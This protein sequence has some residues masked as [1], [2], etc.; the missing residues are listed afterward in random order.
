M[1]TAK[2]GQDNA[3]QECGQDFERCPGHWGYIKL[4]TPKY[5]PEFFDYVKK[6]LIC[7]CL[8]C[9]ALISEDFPRTGE[10]DKIINAA[11]AALVKKKIRGTHCRECKAPLHATIQ[12]DS[13]LQ[14]SLYIVSQE[15]GAPARELRPKRAR[16]ILSR[17]STDAYAM[18]GFSPSVSHPKYFMCKNL[19][20]PPINIRPSD[21]RGRKDVSHNKLTIFLQRILVDNNTLGERIQGLSEAKRKFQSRLRS[22]GLPPETLELL[23]PCKSTL[24]HLEGNVFQRQ[25]DTPETLAQWSRDLQSLAFKIQAR[26]E[27]EEEEEEEQPEN[28]TVGMELA[29]AQDLATLGQLSPG[30][31]VLLRGWEADLKRRKT[32]HNQVCSGPFSGISLPN[33]G[34]SLLVAIE[35]TLPEL[36]ERLER[37][38]RIRTVESWP[39]AE[40]WSKA[41]ARVLTQEKSLQY[42]IVCYV[43]GKISAPKDLPPRT[44]IINTAP[45]YKKESIQGRLKGTETKDGRFRDNISGK[46]NENAGRAVIDPGQENSIDQVTESED[47]AR[48]LTTN[49]FVYAHNIERMR[50]YVANGTKVYPGAKKI[51][52][53]DGNVKTLDGLS[54]AELSDPNIIN[55]GDEVCR[56]LVTDDIV[57]M[58]RQPT[59]HTGS[60]MAHRA[61]VTKQGNTFRLNP[62]VMPPYNADCDG[63]EM[64]QHVPT[65]IDTMTE[66]ETLS[67]T[68]KM[69]VSPGS[70]SPVIGFIQDTL[71]GSRLFLRDAPMFNE[72]ELLELVAYAFREDWDGELPPQRTAPGSG[73]W[74]ASDIFSMLLYPRLCMRKNTKGDGVF[75]ILGGV[76]TQGQISKDILGTAHRSLIHVINNDFGPEAA[77]LFIDRMQFMINHWL[78]SRGFTFSAADLY[79]DERTAGAIRE[80]VDEGV[81]RYMAEN[82]SQSNN[83]QVSIEA[84]AAARDRVIEELEGEIDERR[85]N[86]VTMKVAGS[87]GSQDNIQQMLGSLGQQFVHGK[88]L[89]PNFSRNISN[90][91]SR[92]SNNNTHLFEPTLPERGGTTSVG[93]RRHLEEERY[94]AALGKSK[95]LAQSMFGKFTSTQC[96]F[97]PSAHK[98][99]FVG[100]SFRVGLSAVE[101]FSHAFAGREGLIDTA[102]KTSDIGYLQRKFIK[103]LEDLSVRYDSTVRNARDEVY[104]FSYGNDNFNPIHLESSRLEV[105]QMSTAQREARLFWSAEVEERSELARREHTKIARLLEKLARVSRQFNSNGEIALP[106]DLDRM[107]MSLDCE[108]H[109]LSESETQRIASS[110]SKSARYAEAVVSI[111]EEFRSAYEREVDPSVARKNSSNTIACMLRLMLNSKACLHKWRLSPEGLRHMLFD[112]A[113]RKFLKALVD[114]GEP[115]GPVAAVCIGEPATQMTLNTFHSAGTGGQGSVVATTGV[116]RLTEVTEAKVDQTSVLLDLWTSTPGHEMALCT[117][118]QGVVL[119]DLVIHSQLLLSSEQV[120]RY[121]GLDDSVLRVFYEMQTAFTP[122]YHEQYHPEVLRIVLDRELLEALAISIESIETALRTRKYVADTRLEVIASRRNQLRS[123]AVATIL[124]SNLPSA[125]DQMQLLVERFS[126]EGETLQPIIVERSRKFDL[127]FE[128]ASA[129]QTLELYATEVA[130]FRAS[131]VEQQVALVRIRAKRSARR[132]NPLLA[133]ELRRAILEDA[134]IG[135][136]SFVK[137]S[138]VHTEKRQVLNPETGETEMLD[139]TRV[140]LSVATESK[141]KDCLG[142][143]FMLHGI[144]HSRVYSNNIHHIYET[145]G[146]GAAKIAIYKEVMKVYKNININPRLVMLMVNAMTRTGQIVSC[147]WFGI[148]KTERTDPIKA[149]MFERCMKVLPRASAYGVRNDERS[150]NMAIMNTQGFPMGT[151]VVEIEDNH[152]MLERYGIEQRAIAAPANAMLARYARQGRSRH[153]DESYLFESF[154]YDP[155][156]AKKRSQPQYHTEPEEKRIKLY[157]PLGGHGHGARH[158]PPPS[159]RVQRPLAMNQKDSAAKRARIAEKFRQEN[160]HL[161]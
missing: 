122:T 94:N 16:K 138:K 145:L 147:N 150:I 9:C 56:M 161:F 19:P 140:V 4:V 124:K 116:P 115:V 133:K 89:E 160:P 41:F 31:L 23:L 78:E 82:A 152:E 67:K 26:L 139:D 54:N 49:E 84:L 156:L 92:S 66:I 103:T 106:V 132:P 47:M 61:K 12:A 37:A 126:I 62:A 109:T 97:E 128:H 40:E 65:Y 13:R 105:I 113:K 102:A 25:S 24:D 58:N 108:Q 71:L 148:N 155:K 5:K 46:R 144:D 72:R 159:P 11:A 3:C 88:P 149:M 114:P 125:C 99:G 95:G 130:E 20:V 111:I 48:D 154:K 119:S 107:V 60:I 39:E 141:I 96:V 123:I 121:S 158:P 86:M 7:V 38:E 101:Y 143:V 64:N 153:V 57:L 90:M 43:T 1:G 79:V 18:L 52:Y 135:G 14:N 81:L 91:I 75:E 28:I 70:S 69:I 15:L 104:Q 110:A 53:P 22:T 8:E 42:T 129:E 76:Y 157:T 6:I 74:S 136:L 120:D 137:N 21:F 35:Q 93:M 55:I 85:N 112:L 134:S 63:D 87:K 131:V 98:I 30:E 80:A 33:L 117:N 36:R 118:V 100:S 2:S 32:K 34:I 127:Y 17:V 59:L 29:I 27:L 73:L 45:T 83:E 50:R 146:I 51:I 44:N 77:R 10:P 68:E 142:Q 151:G